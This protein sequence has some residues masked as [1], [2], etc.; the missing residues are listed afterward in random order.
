ME[1][2]K[3][4]IKWLKNMIDLHNQL[5]NNGMKKVFEMKLEELLMDVKELIKLE[6]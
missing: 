4:K 6:L 3:I 2:L 5:G 1:D